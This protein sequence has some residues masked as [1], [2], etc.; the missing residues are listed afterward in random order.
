MCVVKRNSNQSLSLPLVYMSIFVL[1]NVHTT[2]CMYFLIKGFSFSVILKG[3]RCHKCTQVYKRRHQGIGQQL[4]TLSSDISVVLD[5]VLSGS[6]F[7]L[8]GLIPGNQQKHSKSP[9]QRDQLSRKE[10]GH[11]QGPTIVI[12]DEPDDDKSCVR[13][14]S[15]YRFSDNCSP[16]LLL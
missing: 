6:C 13:T 14:P 4:H 7:A 11:H 3:S 1:E 10:E 5:I 8:G 9:V 2:K 16:C 15:I 12:K